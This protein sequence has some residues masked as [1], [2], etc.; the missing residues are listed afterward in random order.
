MI[1]DKTLLK[2]LKMA[3][4]EKPEAE[5]YLTKKFGAF[6]SSL[7]KK[8]IAVLPDD[9]IEP[10]YNLLNKKGATIADVSK[11]FSQPKLKSEVKDIYENEVQQFFENFFIEAAQQCTE[12]QRK[13][14]LVFLDSFQRPAV[15][16]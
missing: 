16:S 12:K 8:I 7:G 2:I 10:Y 5:K 13:Q 11:F 9:Y 15:I 1:T 14:I 3:G 4:Y 6:L